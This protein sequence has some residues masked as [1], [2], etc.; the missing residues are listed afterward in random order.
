MIKRLIFLTIILIGTSSVFA[1]PN[2]MER[3]RPYYM[4]A[5][6]NCEYVEEVYEMFEAVKNP[7]AKLLAYKAALQAIMTK[8][9]WN[10]FKKISYL[11]DC[12][13]SFNK[14][15]ELEPNNI[16]VRFMR[17][18]VEHEIPA[19]L[20]YSTHMEE[21]KKFVVENIHQFNPYKLDPQILE[22][23]LAFVR[24]SNRF[25]PSEILLFEDR[26]ASIN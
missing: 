4:K 24:N 19:Y 2:E 7:S 15:M 17:L 3:L 13:A 23:I 6:H 18:S 25:S 16:E 21:D 22:E 10:V 11:N 20:G 14:A 8:T 12:Q 9:T 26:L 1:G 5:L